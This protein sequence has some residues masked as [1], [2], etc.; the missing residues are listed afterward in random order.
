MIACLSRSL[1]LSIVMAD[2]SQCSTS[3]NER[4]QSI[5]TVEQLEGVIFQRASHPSIQTS[6][7]WRIGMTQR[8]PSYLSSP[9]SNGNRSE[10]WG[11]IEFTCPLLFA[12]TPG[13]LMRQWL[14][15]SIFADADVSSFN[16]IGEHD[17]HRHLLFPNLVFDSK[18]RSMEIVSLF[19][20]TE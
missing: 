11:L 17:N 9:A 6:N 20:P 3:T 15:Q 19:S 1:L 7:D 2:L 14:S 10:R 13:E 4:D 5:V 8:E 18:K 16:H 12:F